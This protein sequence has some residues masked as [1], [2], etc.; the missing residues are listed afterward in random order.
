MK[1]GIHLL[2]F[3]ASSSVGRFV[4][5]G[6]FDTALDKLINTTMAEVLTTGSMNELLHNS[7]DTKLSH[8]PPN[9]AVERVR[10]GMGFTTHIVEYISRG[11][12]PTSH[13]KYIVEMLGEG[14]VTV[15]LDL[16]NQ[17]GRGDMRDVVETEEVI[18]YLTT[19]KFRI[20]GEIVEGYLSD[21]TLWIEIL[22]GLTDK[23]S[24]MTIGKKKTFYMKRKIA[25]RIG[26]LIKCLEDDMKREFFGVNKYWHDGFISFMSLLTNLVGIRGFDGYSP[27][28][29]PI[30]IEQEGLVE[31][32]LRCIFWGDERPEIIQEARLNHDVGAIAQIADYAGGVIEQMMVLGEMEDNPVAVYYTGDGWDLNMRICNTIIVSEAFDPSYNTTL[33]IGMLGLLKGGKTNEIMNS[34]PWFLDESSM[35]NIMTALAVTGCVTDE[36]YGALVEVGNRDRISFDDATSVMKLA[37]E[38]EN[39]FTSHS[40]QKP[41]DDRVAMAIQAGILE[42]MLKFLVQFKSQIEKNND[43]IAHIGMFLQGALSVS[44]FDKC[45]KA[46][47]DRKDSIVEALEEYDKDPHPPQEN[48]AFFYNDIVSMIRSML[49]LNQADVSDVKIH[50]FDCSS[51]IDEEKQKLCEE[52]NQDCHCTGDC[53]VQHWEP[54]TLKASC[55]DMPSHEHGRLSQLEKNSY[56]IVE[57]VMSNGDTRSQILVNAT[58]L[59]LDILD[60]VVMIDVRI[61]PLTVE[62]KKLSTLFKSSWTRKNNHLIVLLTQRDRDSPLTMPPDE[63]HESAFTMPRIDHMSNPFFFHKISWPDAQQKLEIYFSGRLEELKDN[64]E[65]GIQYLETLKDEHSRIFIEQEIRTNSPDLDEET[66]QEAVEELMHFRKT[67]KYRNPLYNIEPHE[68]VEEEEEDLQCSAEE[69]EQEDSGTNEKKKSDKAVEHTESVSTTWSLLALF[70]LILILYPLVLKISQHFD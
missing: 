50:C 26:P 61:P 62:V 1:C 23:S 59:G 48:V 32:L 13:Q 63:E 41:I 34:R 22:V 3:L 25:R 30:L 10:Q 9:E 20:G 49:E 28:I 67:G 17:C 19:F 35:W 37:Y 24:E 68:E 55:N 58:L 54:D 16:V 51:L 27:E 31:M 43:L 47:A 14:L 56:K 6:D 4:Y 45:T 39:V 44:Q 33:P 38:M 42:L 69:Y 29:I 46:I 7:F 12:G 36:M 57:K 66:I 18:P 8:I 21:P 5:G 52:C 2:L 64:P 40:M 11:K 65:L 53:Q 60:S 15:V 70:F